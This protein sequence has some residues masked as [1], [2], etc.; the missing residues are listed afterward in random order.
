METIV[1]AIDNFNFLKL[2]SFKD[3][4]LWDVKRLVAER[5]ASDFPIVTLGD[6][7]KEEN[8]KIRPAQ[9]PEKEHKILGVNNIDGIFDAYTQLGKEIK[10]PYKVMNEGFL[11]YNPYR[12]NVGSIGLKSKEHQND[13]ISPAYVVFSCKKG[14]IPDFLYKLFKTERFNKVIR[15]NTTGSVRQ[16]LT[17]DILRTLEIPLPKPTEQE[18]ILADYNA[19]MQEAERL[20][21]E[22]EATKQ[23]FQDVIFDEL[24]LNRP[25][26]YE[27]TFGLQFVNFK[28]LVTWNFRQ[29]SED[30]QLKSKKYP[31]TSIEKYPELAVS[32]FRGKNPK[33]QD[34]TEAIILNQKCNR[35]NA[36]ELEHAKTVNPKWL[37]SLSEIDFTK[38]GDILINSTGEGTIGRATTITKEFAGLMY[39]THMLLLRLNKEKVNPEFFT[40]LFNSSYGQKQVDSI[41]SAQSTK[42]TEL[43]VGNLKKIHFPLPTLEEQILVVDKL[44]QLEERQREIENEMKNLPDQAIKDFEAKIFKN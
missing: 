26:Q 6:Y 22:I 3:F 2:V 39:D 9:E 11:A 43:G 29:I 19:K 23:V 12:I 4:T 14:L 40:Y 21:V 7:I 35:W 32:V 38:E 33:Y 27:Y 5:I 31:V 10:Q 36:I 30:E 13:L 25:K 41:K 28:D 42:Q 18:E 17:I 24:A 20:K 8:T 34:D 1:K 44:K 37:A 16:N 15:D